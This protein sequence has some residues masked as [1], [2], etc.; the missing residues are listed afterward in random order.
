MPATAAEWTLTFTEKTVFKGSDGKAKSIDHAAV[1][2]TTG[3]VTLDVAHKWAETAKNSFGDRFDI[4]ITNTRTA[5]AHK[6]EEVTGLST[7]EWTVKFVERQK[8]RDPITNQLVSLGRA[9]ITS[10]SSAMAIDTALRLARNNL[11]SLPTTEITLTNSTTGEAISA[12]T[13][14]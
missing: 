3:A 8:F 2:S 13:L 7:N 1:T 5:E 12:D 4:K 11:K 6:I 10:T 9:S 14:A